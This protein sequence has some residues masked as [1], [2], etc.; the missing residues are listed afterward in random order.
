VALISGA[1]TGPEGS[2]QSSFTPTPEMLTLLPSLVRRVAP[3]TDW[4]AF[5]ELTC[6]FRAQ[7]PDLVHTH[8]GKAGFL[9]RLAAHRAGVRCIVHTIHGPS[10]GRFQGALANTALRAAERW[11]GR[12]TTHF[13]SVADAMTNQYL[14]AGIGTPSQ[15]TRIFSGFD[16]A[17]FLKA[18][19]E[20]ALRAQWG[21]RPDDFVV[22]K[23]ARLVQLKGHEDLLAAAPTLVARCPKIKFLLVGD[24][25]LRARWEA[26]VRALGLGKHFVFAGLASPEQI[27]SLIGIMDALV[28][29]SRRE[30]LPRALPQALAAGRPVIACD[31]DGAREVCLPNQT[32]FLI[33]PG[34][35]DA[36]A[37]H[38]LTLAAD[39][40][41]RA[42]LGERGQQF[43]RERFPAQRMV[44]EL[45]ALYQ[46]LLA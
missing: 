16:L 35:I 11:A 10:F 40:P 13:V 3:L 22:G 2:L 42:D 34:A 24:G 43:V 20:P 37:E 23:I 28:H 8:S 6:I 14:A 19:N 5:R 12:R 45:Y 32:G 9:G 27:P 15:Y 33:Q 25:P 30:G 38:L 4:K 46:R 41:L 21:I 36:L 18:K 26:A 29:L 7:A 44:D 1:E 39:A 31:C 17:P